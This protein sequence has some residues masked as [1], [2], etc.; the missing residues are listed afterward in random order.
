ML[1]KHKEIQDKVFNEII[2]VVGDDKN[3]PITL[4]QLQSLKYMEAVIKETFRLLP[5][6][7]AIGRYV[8]SDIK[9]GK[10]FQIAR[11]IDKN[12]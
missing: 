9:L 2:D 7:P 4:R 12:L 8:D 3:A 5:P 6:V 1:S 11:Y 10:Y